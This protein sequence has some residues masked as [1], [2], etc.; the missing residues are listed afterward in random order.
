MFFFP[1]ENKFA[2]IGAHARCWRREYTSLKK[3]DLAK[4][5]RVKF[6]QIPA[7]IFI[8][9]G[10]MEH[11]RGIERHMDNK[12]EEGF[13]LSKLDITNALEKACESLENENPSTSMSIKKTAEDIQDPSKKKQDSTR[14]ESVQ[15]DCVPSTSSCSLIEKSATRSEYIPGDTTE[16]C[17]PSCGQ[18]LDKAKK[19]S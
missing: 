14:A 5:Y 12:I 18:F 9:K 7:G 16:K 13:E 11:L 8:C 15:L 3:L 10:P 2:T 17:C 1:G 6:L 19:V 4:G